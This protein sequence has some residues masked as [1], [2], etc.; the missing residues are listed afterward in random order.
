LGLI[1]PEGY[2]RGCVE[3]GKPLESEIASVEIV[4]PWTQA[5]IQSEMYDVDVDWVSFHAPVDFGP[6]LH[7]GSAVDLDHFESGG[8][9][10][11]QLAGHS[12]S[13]SG[14]RDR[15]FGRRDMRHFGRHWGIYVEGV[16]TDVFLAYNSVS[17]RDREYQLSPNH[18]VGCLWRD[19]EGTL[20]EAPAVLH[21]S[22]DAS[23]VRAYLPDGI[24]VEMDLG[25][26]IGDQRHIFD[27]NSGPPSDDS[28][29]EVYGTRDYYLPM[30]S[31]QLGRLIG[32]YEE[33]VLWT[34]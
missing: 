20:Y 4:E 26:S 31:P 23:P 34:N 27:P 16:D 24:E 18:F 13:G 29:A 6:V 17:G 11:G 9:G 25:K 3:T 10:H 15:S 8:R 30:D 19:G 28:S 32:C 33:G 2:R 14:C 22:R 12:V 21:R 5:R 7:M 1:T